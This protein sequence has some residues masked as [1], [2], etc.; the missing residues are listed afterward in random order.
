MIY[1]YKCE[2]CQL[3]TEIKKPMAEASKEEFCPACS[4]KLT[5]RFAPPD[6]IWGANEWDFSHGGMGT[7]DNPGEME[8][9]HHQ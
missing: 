7:E 8:L 5:R 4:N 3:E 1:P 2:T 6:W 9:R